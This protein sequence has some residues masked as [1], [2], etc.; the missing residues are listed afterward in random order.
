MNHLNDVLQAQRCFFQ[1]GTTLSVE[2]RI[3]MLKKLLNAIHA[4]ESEINDA[5]YADLGKS[6]FEGFMCEIGMACSEISYMIRNTKSFAREK[7]VPTPLA[8]FPSRSYQ[9]PSPYG[10]VL[11]MSPWN[12]P[13]LLTIDPLANAIAAG[14][15]AIVKPSA[16]SPATANIVEKIITECFNP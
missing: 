12:Y 1:S 15:T 13:F 9:K 14:N 6:N 4:H 11:I 10:N 5:L 3:A 7:R 16:Y 8:Q 2:F